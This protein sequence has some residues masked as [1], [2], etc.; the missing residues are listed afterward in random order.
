MIFEVNEHSWKNKQ[1]YPKGVFPTDITQADS[2]FDTSADQIMFIF[3]YLSNSQQSYCFFS[4]PS[5]STSPPWNNPVWLFYTLMW[6]NYN[7]YVFN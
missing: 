1:F 7:M 5:I 3:A 6:A 4:P 2:I